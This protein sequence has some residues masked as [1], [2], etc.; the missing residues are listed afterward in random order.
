MASIRTQQKARAT[1][2]LGLATLQTMTSLITTN[3]ENGENVSDQSRSSVVRRQSIRVGATLVAA[4]LA[5]EGLASAAEQVGEQADA[6]ESS[7]L[8]EI[9]LNAPW[10][11]DGLMTFDEHLIQ[12]ARSFPEF[13]GIYVDPGD[14]ET[15]RIWMMPNAPEETV[16]LAVQRLSSELEDPEILRMD[17]KVVEAQY[18]W[19]ELGEWMARLMQG[20]HLDNVSLYDILDSA[21]RINLVVDGLDE[22]IDYILMRARELGVP[23][24]A[25]ILEDGRSGSG[26]LRSYRDP[27]RGGLEV[28]IGRF[29][30]PANGLPF[31]RCTLGIPVDRGGHRGYLTASHCT[32]RMGGSADNSLM[33]QN[34][35][36]TGEG[37]SIGN[38]TRDGQ[39]T[40]HSNPNW[41]EPNRQ[42]RYADVSFFRN[43]GAR[44]S[45]RGF[46]AW[47]NSVG[48]IVFGGTERR[49]VGRH[50]V[51]QGQ[52][53]AIVGRTS[54]R[55]EG[56]VTRVCFHPTDNSFPSSQFPFSHNRIQWMCQNGHNTRTGG[57][58]SG[59]AVFRRQS[60]QPLDAHFVGIQS[61]RVADIGN[62]SYFS[63]ISGIIR[64]TEQ[65]SSLRVCH[66]LELGC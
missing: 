50:N 15:L 47:P 52:A 13:G 66:W 22:S 5:V 6:P 9:A 17:V 32:P 54:G 11:N 16:S 34:H 31:A 25:L 42:C 26:Q 46:V 19:L 10:P 27:L 57:G 37:R 18:S 38:E 33:G 40:G 63:P 24:E 61:S 20:L 51:L 28:E 64:S 4:A 59:S 56:N 53:V 65:G 44:A 12:V 62:E 35:I 55:R 43:N 58:D 41:C 3:F 7:Q 2:R 8:Q 30:R 39:W 45:R 60:G 36:I 1:C 14:E 49:I 21:N 23:S 29:S 48:S